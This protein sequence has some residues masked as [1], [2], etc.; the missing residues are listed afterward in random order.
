MYLDIDPFLDQ[1]PQIKLSLEF[2]GVCSFK[3]FSIPFDFI[4]DEY[5]SLLDSSRVCSFKQLSNLFDFIRREIFSIASSSLREFPRSNSFRFYRRRIFFTVFRELARSNI[6]PNIRFSIF[7]NMFYYLFLNVFNLLVE[8]CFLLL[9]RS[10]S[11]VWFVQTVWNFEGSNKCRVLRQ[12]W[13]QRDSCGVV[14]R[15]SNRY[16]PII[17]DTRNS[18]SSYA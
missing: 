4:V 14:V 1:F 10:F 2:Y 3:Q 8:E 16:A 17:S 15:I 7:K 11:R 6:S 5:F 9:L 12:V 13:T 18:C